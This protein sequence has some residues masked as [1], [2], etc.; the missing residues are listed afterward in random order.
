MLR[1]EGVSK[2][3]GGLT[4]LAG[5]DLEVKPGEA[6]GVIGPNGSGKTAL[7]NVITGLYP[8]SAGRVWLESREITGLRPDRI[9]RLGVARTF[10]NL[11][12]FARMTAFDNVWA[13]QHRLP[14][15]AVSE[16]MVPRRRRERER[17]ARVEHLLEAVGL[18]DRRDVLAHHLPLG[19]QRR[20]ELARAL[21]REPRL[22]LLDEPAGGM[23]P[24]ETEEMT[25]L[26]RE[27]AL[28]GRTVLLIEHKM[29][30]VMGLCHRIVVLNF[31]KKISEGSPEDVQADPAVTEAYLGTDATDA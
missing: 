11:R 1:I 24:V 26:I 31:G 22:L 18:E 21:A 28:P 3:F 2:S 20:L 12:I 4:A 7:F 17:L 23:T 29:G 19:A 30:M 10:Q 6:L 27:I 9:V 15:V 25:R 5:V 14:G 16:L 8:P 13:A